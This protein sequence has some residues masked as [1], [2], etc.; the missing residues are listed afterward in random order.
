MSDALIPRE[1][2]VPSKYGTKDELAAVTTP[3]SFLPY[4]RLFGSSTEAVKKNLIPQAHY[5]LTVQK[6]EIIDLGKEIDVLPVSWRPKAMQFG[7]DSPIS[8]FNPKT[9]EFQKVKD[10]AKIQNSG[11]TYGPEFLL[12]IPKVQ[13]FCTFYLGS[14]TGRRIGDEFASLMGHGV[15]LNSRLVEW[16]DKKTKRDFSWH[17]PTFKICQTRFEIPIKEEIIRVRDSF[18]NP[19]DSSIEFDPEKL[20]EERA[21]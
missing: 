19:D 12:Y 21:R 7:G 10:E 8:Y 16:F 2:Y 3:V 5:G 11:A 15:T 20:E 14:E 6:D 9:P 1:D 4:L 17:A 13:R 18:N